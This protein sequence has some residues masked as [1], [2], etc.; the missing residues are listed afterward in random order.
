MNLFERSQENLIKRRNNLINGN[1][2]S[3]PSPFIRFRNDFIG[4]EKG[5]YICVTSFTKG[6]KTQFVLNL[7][8]EALCYYKDNPNAFKM[9]VF[10]F[11]LEE[12]DERILN[13]FESYLLLKLDKI[14]ISPKDL[15]SS[16]ND[17]PV[18]QE[19]LNLLSS[20]KYQE[21]IKLF[22][23][24]FEFD[25]VSNPTGIYLKC[26]KFAE[27]NGTIFRRKVKYKNDF[28][29]IEESDMGFDHYEPKDENLF[30]FPVIDHLGLVTPER[31]QTL[32]EAL[33][34]V[35]KYCVELR[36]NYNFSPIVIQQQNTTNESNDS[37]KMDKIRPSGRGLADSSYIQRDVNLLLGLSSPFKFGVNS[38]FGYDITQFRDNIRFLEI[39]NNRDG[40]VGG[41]VALYF[42]GATTTFKELP[43]AD[44][45]HQVELQR[46]YNFLKKL[47]NPI[48]VETKST[49]NL[50]YLYN[51]SKKETLYGKC[52]NYFRK[53][54]NRKINK[55]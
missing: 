52:C 39:V 16:S 36:N 41:I 45:E 31:G 2:N 25:T 34:K 43:I 15:R 42:D 20:D 9:K 53:F 7:L 33:D 10:Y 48:K 23:E 4:L 14:R 17:K 54:W 55:C 12:T 44:E 22:L 21:Y 28:G 5:Q 40:E 50:F 24:V 8:F 49:N 13:R 18:P 11:A 37:I 47:R 3:I 1:V 38:Y 51:N 35:S 6:G 29:E 27:E 30:V 19:I 32:K 46:W 26:R